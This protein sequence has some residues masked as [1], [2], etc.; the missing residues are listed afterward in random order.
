MKFL[1]Q[2]HEG[3]DLDVRREA[4]TFP[5]GIDDELA[6]RLK[7]GAGGVKTALHLGCQAA[8][9]LNR[10]QTAIRPGQQQ[11]NLGTA[12]GTVKIA[13]YTLWG[14]GEQIFD[15]EAFPTLAEHGVGEQGFLVRDSQQ[16]VDQ[17]AVAYINLG[18][19]DQT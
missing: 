11:V 19:F 2:P 16:G 6:R 8:L 13:L 9:D 1:R 10:P 18:R 3:D 12:A 17:A 15:D 7:V 5:A 14:T 4:V